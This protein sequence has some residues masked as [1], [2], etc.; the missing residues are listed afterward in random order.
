M[1]AAALVS[2]DGTT[3]PGT[4]AVSP[5]AS[6][7]GPRGTW[8]ARTG[9][10][11][12]GCRGQLSSGLGQGSKGRAVG[13]EACPTPPWHLAILARPQTA[14]FPPLDS[15]LG[16]FLLLY[17]S[18]LPSGRAQASGGSIA[19]LTPRI[20][21]PATHAPQ[22]LSH[23]WGHQLSQESAWLLS[24]SSPQ[25]SVLGS[26]TAAKTSPQTSTPLLFKGRQPGPPPPG[27]QAA[28]GT[29]KA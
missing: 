11:S 8:K 3:G 16:L 6:E 1:Q 28:N 29:G 20:P 2:R 15:S 27:Q 5:S 7:S 25:P 23:L 14:H 13:G 12:C 9:V 4:G 17:T 18:L 26:G 21:P 22:E 10:K 24:S 19:A